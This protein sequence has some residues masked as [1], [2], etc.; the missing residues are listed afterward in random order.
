[1]SVNMNKI[2]FINAFK[3]GFKAVYLWDGIGDAK[4]ERL[5]QGVVAEDFDAVHHVALWRVHSAS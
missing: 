1:M 5:V 2:C 3:E 4:A